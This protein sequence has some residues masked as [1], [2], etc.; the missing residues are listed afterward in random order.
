MLFDALIEVGVVA[1]EA[2]LIVYYWGHC[3]GPALMIAGARAR[4]LRVIQ[5]VGIGAIVSFVVKAAL[6]LDGRPIPTG[7]FVLQAILGVWY[8]AAW[9]APELVAR[10][11][12]GRDQREALRML[13][14]R[15]NGA[16]RRMWDGIDPQQARADLLDAT[17]RLRTF[18]RTPETAELI[19]A[20]LA[21]MDPD[22]GRGTAEDRDNQR[23]ETMIRESRRLW[24]DFQ[25]GR[26]AVPFTPG[27]TDWP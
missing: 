12:G 5:A 2:A 18:P 14:W 8:L 26:V 4:T 24:P 15:V 3:A 1:L 9:P 10:I 21:D 20:W 27:G 19:E 6:W 16:R 23:M 25:L 13:L 17:D 22:E 11:S 7:L